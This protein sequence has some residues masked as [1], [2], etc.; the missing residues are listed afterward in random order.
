MTR[1]FRAPGRVNLIG[2]HTDYNLGFVMPAAINLWT[3][4]RI[5]PRQD[6]LVLARS[7]QFPD[8]FQFSL[9]DQDAA[10]R[11]AWA[12]Y[13]QGVALAIE[14]NGYRLRG[15]ELE[16]SSTVPIGAGL[17]SSAALE[18][19]TALALAAT[20]AHSLPLRELAGLCQRAENDFVGMRC[21]IMDQFAATHGVRDHALLLDCRSLDFKLSPLPPNVRLVIC[22]SMVRHELTGSEYNHRRADCETAARLLGVASLRDAAAGS[23]DSLPEPARRRARHVISEIRRTELAAGALLAGDLPRFGQL[24]YE[25]HDS[26]RTDYEVSCAELDLLVDLARAARGV[27]GARL[28]GAGFGGCTINLV[29]EARMGEFRRGI[30]PAYHQQT[31]IEPEIYICQ[32][33]NGAEEL[34]C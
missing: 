31:G 10:P 13:V 3:S 27:Y 24:M 33:V 29:D 8:T 5:T 26:L 16:I 11:K 25:S 18:V 7:G 23:A 4:V 19:S 6:R 12:D 21:G 1:L 17:S 9:D 22:N 20:S 34:P 32:A 2:E 30:A 14:E 28:T 15:A